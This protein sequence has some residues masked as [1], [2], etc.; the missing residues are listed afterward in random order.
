ME[1]LFIINLR[2][3]REPFSLRKVFR[4]AYRAGASEKLAQEIALDVQGKAYPGIK[5]TEIFR[6]VKILLKKEDSKAG[7]RFN[8]REAIKRLGP[9]G[10]PFEKYIGDIFLAQE[11][12]VSLSQKI[13][14][15]WAKHEVDFLA[16]K[17]KLLYVGECK[18]RIR[19]GERI[20]LK[21][22][23]AVYAR[24]LDL[25][26]GNYF[27]KVKESE[28][29][30][31]L[32]TNAKFTSQAVRYS[33]GVGIE[34]L[35]WNYP[36]NKGLEKIVESKKLYP[37]TILPSLNGSL[38]EV[39]ASRNMMVIQDIL[40][41]NVEKFSQETETKKAKILSLVD[42]AKILVGD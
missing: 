10:F 9:S 37:I 15:Q 36:R 19:P 18:F 14:G 32:V 39:F 8:L 38:M 30:P 27:K 16:E 17:N 35:G 4:S 26:K 7:L 5:T 21:V 2:G 20:D 29:K 40:E 13:Y 42:E 24:F 33:Q 12:K 1:N 11:F 28:L 22:A 3:E 31:I 25:E 41:I 34:L 6:E 23:L